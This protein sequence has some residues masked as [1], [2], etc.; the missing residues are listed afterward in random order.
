[1]AT[2][3]NAKYFTTNNIEQATRIVNGHNSTRG[4]IPYQA[5]LFSRIRSNARRICGGVLI[6][7]NYILTTAR[8]ISGADSFTVHLGALNTFNETEPGRVTRHTNR[9]YSHPH[10]VPRFKWNDIAIV[11]WKEPVNFTDS[12]Q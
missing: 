6:T 8:C 1:M 7:P 10:Y 5:L 4:E 9:S 3:T 12:M 11:S 2:F